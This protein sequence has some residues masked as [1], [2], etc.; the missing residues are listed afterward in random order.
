MG[1]PWGDR[2]PRILGTVPDFDPRTYGCPNLSTLSTK[3][4]GFEIRKGPGNAVH[5]RRKVS[6]RKAPGKSG[7]GKAK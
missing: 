1:A 4:G 3:S 5:I 7:G 2:Q 6:G